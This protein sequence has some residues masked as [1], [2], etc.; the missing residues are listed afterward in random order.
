V[1]MQDLGRMVLRW[2]YV[3]L[4]MIAVV[5]VLSTLSLTDL[6]TRDDETT[7]MD[8][9]SQARIDYDYF[10]E[11]FGSDRFIVV[12]YE[13][14]D[15]FSAE[16]IE[17]LDYLTSRLG[18]LPHVSEAISLTTI[19][20]TRMTGAGSA[21]RTF[22]KRSD[23]PCSEAERSLLEARIAA[24]PLVDG[25][26][27]SG[28][29]R[30]LA[31]VL[32]VT[33]TLNGET[34]RAI[35]NALDAS[36]DYESRLTGRHFY[37]GGGPVY[38]AKIN[39]IMERDV[40]VFTPLVLVL[41]GIVLFW[42]FHS[43]RAAALTLLAVVL[44]ML[45][46][47]G[48]KGA[49]GSPVTPVST[50][51]V[52]LIV[53]IGVAN[54]VHFISHYQLELTRARS[55]EEA[56][57]DT[58]SRAGTPCLLTSLTTA[59]G[60]ASLIVSDIP[61]IRHLGT[62]AGFGIMSAFVLTMIL[63]PVGLR[64]SPVRARQKAG[65]HDIWA[66][67]GAFVVQHSQV[68]LLAWAA[69]ALVVALGVFKV[70]VE[71]SMT[72]YLKPDSPTRQAADVIDERMAGSSSIELLL[73][74]PPSSFES[75]SVLHTIERL[76]NSLE[77]RAH[78]A[79]TISAADFVVQVSGGRLPLS[80]TQAERA[81]T[82]L[83]REDTSNFSEYYVQG[84]IDSMRICI[85]TKQMP[86]REREDIIHQIE[87][88]ARDNLQGFSF[89]ITGAEGLVSAVTIDVVRTQ[90]LSVIIA[91][92]VIL[93]LMVLFFGGRGA[94]AAIMPN[95]MPILILFGVMGLGGFELNIATTTVAAICIGL[96]VDDT[97]HYFSHFRRLVI[98]S[99]Q[100]EQAAVTAL[101]EVGS[102]FAFTALT[103]SLGFCVFMLSES[104][105]LVQFGIL[106]VTALVTAFV[107]DITVGP[108]ILSRYSVFGRT[109]QSNKS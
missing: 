95:V 25:A 44:A 45:W 35:T 80:D 33:S 68:V 61:L 105:F 86:M 107:A 48:L 89:T 85:R 19:K 81:L 91:V 26:L 53:I 65:P 57:V 98:E 109:R 6:E 74:G 60:F 15:A 47:F 58:F 79:Q 103:L 50:T 67:T 59:V 29:R 51:L 82:C 96:V 94:L 8:E 31:I 73:Q 16:E 84:D 27:V 75:V 32:K 63:V 55:P 102:A 9:D 7:W 49:T 23:A 1:D 78:V 93:G 14:P 106:S 56:M 3:L 52:A 72:G 97:I 39:A 40:R 71:P 77:N 104:A 99:G 101:Q 17:Y 62:Y 100:P 42:L 90:I 64:N 5:S 2:R 41:S 76:Q 36:L 108:A 34:Y 24:N 88:F 28:D 22:L 37:Y 18:S 11:L 10:R 54:S 20:E 43:W 83:A 70:E 13:T 87:D 46:T 69:F 38:D 12:A 21:S 92:A 4:V 30:M 66:S